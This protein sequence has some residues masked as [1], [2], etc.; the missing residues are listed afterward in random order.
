ME[1]L[2]FNLLY[3]WFVGL[4]MDDQVWNH[5]TFSN[6]R[7]RLLLHDVADRFFEAIRDQ[8][9]AKDLLSR[10]TSPSTAR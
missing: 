2:D 6:N 5:S 1:E 9:A 4:S 7:D 8:A 3:R 10:A